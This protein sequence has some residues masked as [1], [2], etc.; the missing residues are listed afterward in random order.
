MLTSSIVR[1]DS[2]TS[3]TSVTMFWKRPYWGDRTLAGFSLK[4]LKVGVRLPYDGKARITP[5]YDAPH[6]PKPTSV[7]CMIRTGMTLQE[8]RRPRPAEQ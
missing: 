5:R 1:F 6:A 3:L 4:F 7:I 8:A 2:K